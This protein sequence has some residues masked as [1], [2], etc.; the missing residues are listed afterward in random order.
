MFSNL[1]GATKIALAVSAM[2]LVLAGA[3]FYYYFSN[4]DDQPPQLTTGGDLFKGSVANSNLYFEF[5]T[6]GGAYDFP[7]SE[8]KNLKS[9]FNY[10]YAL[11]D[12]KVSEIIN[13]IKPTVGNKILVIYYNPAEKA[14]ELYKKGPYVGTEEISDPDDYTIPAFHGFMILSR[15]NT[16][17]HNTIKGVD[18]KFFEIVMAQGG[19]GQLLGNLEEYIN[20]LEGWILLPVDIVGS[21]D[22]FLEGV[23]D[24]VLLVSVL[25]DDESGFKAATKDVAGEGIPKKGMAW[26]KFGTLNCTGGKYPEYGECK[27]CAEGEVLKEDGSGCEDEGGH[28]LSFDGVDDYIKIPDNSTLE[29]QNISAG[30]FVKILGPG[31]HVSQGIDPTDAVYI[32]S[33]GRKG[34]APNMSY[35]IYYRPTMKRF[36]CWFAISGTLSGITSLSTHPYPSPWTNVFCTY[37]GSAISLYINGVLDKTAN[38]TGPINYQMS[39]NDDLHIGDWGY[40]R[41]IRRFH[42]LIKDVRVYDKALTADEISQIYSGTNLTSG[43]I[44]HW[45]L[46]EG[47]GTIATDSSGNNNNGT[48]F[49]GPVWSTDTPTP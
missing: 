28:A 27:S 30:A 37:D 20:A 24:R 31:S 22:E 33:K 13:Y 6:P 39:Y 14:F 9:G 40:D 36:G 21:L 8:L 25:K 48:L 47:E 44:G 41:F 45:K 19:M 29:A 42:G 2:I 26:V 7:P 15:D 49:N 32:L 4:G 34:T 43:L 12:L 11:Q 1:K 38:Y 35:G 17:I 5:K 16:K 3:T 46:D 10:V 23:K 18:D